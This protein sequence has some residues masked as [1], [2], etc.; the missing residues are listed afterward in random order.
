MLINVGLRGATSVLVLPLTLV[1]Y[2][3]G[4]CRLIKLNYLCYLLIN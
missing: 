1:G 2:F 3:E 4:Q